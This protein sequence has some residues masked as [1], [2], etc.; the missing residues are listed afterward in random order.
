MVYSK[1]VIFPIVTVETQE[2]IEF[3]EV[4]TDF[5]NVHYTFS[6]ENKEALK[7]FYNLLFR[8]TKTV[9]VFV[10]SWSFPHSSTVLA[11]GLKELKNKGSET[12]TSIIEEFH[13][14]VIK[15]PPIKNLSKGK[16]HKLGGGPFNDSKGSA[17]NLN[18]FLLFL[19]QN[20]ETNKKSKQNLDFLLK[21]TNGTLRCPSDFTIRNS[22]YLPNPIKSLNPNIKIRLNRNLLL[23]KGGFAEM[24]GEKNPFLFLPIYFRLNKRNVFLALGS[25]AIGFSL[26]FYF[27]KDIFS[28]EAVE[29]EEMELNN[30]PFFSKSMLVFLLV[31]L[32]FLFPL[33][34]SLDL[35]IKYIESVFEP[36]SPLFNL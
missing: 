7:N 31:L 28:K 22:Q 25:A 1:K 29:R 19:V 11:V 26:Y 16:A 5:G 32:S 33:S 24:V 34:L 12:I 15:D 6:T 21:V 4:E 10:I 36:T 18:K 8:V 30:T 13:P 3:L 9:T 20:N 14:I 17:N 2:D 23:I 27:Y 35:I